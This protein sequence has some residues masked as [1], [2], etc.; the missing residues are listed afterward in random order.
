M[1]LKLVK[2]A[3]SARTSDT[4]RFKQISS[5]ETDII[6]KQYSGKAMMDFEKFLEALAHVSYLCLGIEG[7]QSILVSSLV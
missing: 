5:R 4:K 7:N 2:E 6:F 1:F 3:S